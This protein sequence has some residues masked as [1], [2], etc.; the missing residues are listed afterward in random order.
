MSSP[1]SGTGPRFSNEQGGDAAVRFLPASGSGKKRRRPSKKTLWKGLALLG[2]AGALALITGL[3]V[4]HFHLREDQKVQKTYVGVMGISDQQFVEAYEEPSS[5]EYKHLAGLVNSQ[6]KVM[7]SKDSVLSKY[8]QESTVKAFSEEEDGIVAY[9]QS[10]FSLPEPRLS[11]LDQAME[12]LE[13]PEGQQVRQGRLLLR[14]T[15][16]LNVHRMVTGALDPRMT[17]PKFI[18]RESTSL[19]VEKKGELRSPGFPESLYNPSTFLQWKLRAQPHHRVRL[20]F[21]S[22]AM[23]ED[24]QKD[25]IKLYDSL[26]PIEH[27]VLAEKCGNVHKPMV[28]LSS[29][30]VMLLTMVTSKENNFRGF[31]ATYSQIPLNTTCGGQLTGLSGDINSPFFP[32]FYPPKTTCVW[33]IQVPKG[34]FIKLQFNDFSLADPAEGK[35]GCT[36]DYVEVNDQRLC[37]KKGSSVITVES[38]KMTVRFQS[39]DSNVDSGF[40]AQYE[41]FVPANPCPGRFHCDNHQCVNLTLQCDGWEDCTDRSDENNCTCQESQ[42]L[43]GNG[44]CKPSFWRCD[45]VDDC[46]D[47]SDEEHCGQCSAGQ[48]RC[49]N[50]RCIPDNQTCDGTNDCSDGSDEAQCKE[51]VEA[52]CSAQTYRCSSGVCI[53]K[54]NPECDGEADCQDAS[55]EANCECGTRPFQSSA[56]VGGEISQVGEWPWQVSLHVRGMGHVCGASVLNDGWLLT[57]AHCVQDDD[58]TRFSRVDL[59]E[60]MLGLHIQGHDSE[61]TV[62]RHLKRIIP[63]PSFDPKTYA[64]DLALMELQKPVALNQNIWPICLPSPAHQ[65]HAGESAWITG[66]G[67][68]REGGFKA[69]IL[70]KAEVRVVNQTVCNTLMEGQITDGMLCAGFLKGGVDACQGDSG[71]PLSITAAAG[72]RVFQAGVV[73]WGDGCARKNRPG[74]YVRVT[75]HRAWIKEHTGL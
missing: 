34:H 53:S 65:F 4:W 2:G 32:A 46:E 42:F 72:G 40:A 23:E 9:Y 18:K 54:V 31:R 25:F 43:C 61:W 8:F 41:A 45:G 74:V 26:V 27:L 19:H 75:H 38:T 67:T 33:N 64:N 20:E 69:A 37:G 71:G 62:R 7:Y 36:K 66:W 60:A 51:G 1:S 13:E 44:R 70:Q 10:E 6:L 28:F 68:T 35:A 57:A 24:C 52:K 17:K 12:S 30:N 58:N 47:G 16:T 59:W 49:H 5:E 63:H 29:E 48:F 39:D 55:D 21:H 3:L 73:S 11:S 56:V 15:N 50:D 22:L 14:P